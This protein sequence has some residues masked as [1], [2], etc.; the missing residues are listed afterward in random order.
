VPAAPVAIVRAQPAAKPVQAR[1]VDASPLLKA[2]HDMLTGLSTPEHLADTGEAW[3]RDLNDR[4]LSLC[5]VHVALEGFESVAERYGQ[6]A[7]DQVLVQVSRRLRNVMRTDDRVM[8]QG[9]AEFVLL[10]SCPTADA[11]R[12]ALNVAKRVLADLQ[13]PIGY[14]TVSNLGVGCSV[15]S[16]LCP[17]DGSTLA[18]AMRHAEEALGWARRSGRGRRSHRGLT[19]HAPRVKKN[20]RP[21]ALVFMAPLLRTATAAS[22]GAA[23]ATRSGMQ[24]PLG[25]PHHAD[26]QHKQDR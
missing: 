5:V 12:L 1:P 23:A 24:L 8:R 7:S 10:V 3:V 26:Q 17:A 22:V 4:G 9:V 21:R 16:A 15:G 11:P 14:R 13:R 25:Q 19:R 18:L 6:D 20:E 2:H